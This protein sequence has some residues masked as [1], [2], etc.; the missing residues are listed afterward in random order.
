M[1][2]DC[3]SL[4]L[5]SSI[6]QLS[7][8]QRFGADPGPIITLVPAFNWKLIVSSMQLYLITGF[9]GLAASIQGAPHP[10]LFRVY[11]TCHTTSRPWSRLRELKYFVSNCRSPRR[12]ECRVR[13]SIIS[14]TNIPRENSVDKFFADYQIPR[15]ESAGI[16]DSAETE[17]YPSYFRDS[18]PMEWNKKFHKIPLDT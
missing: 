1:L 17:V 16:W 7:P 15:N 5:N 12:L 11:S 8:S 6:L 3:Q 18:I 13:L 10:W 14:S 4:L 2:I 9:A